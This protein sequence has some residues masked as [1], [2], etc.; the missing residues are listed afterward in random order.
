MLNDRDEKYDGQDDTEYHFSDEEVSYDVDGSD[1]PKAAAPVSAASAG[2][3]TS[4]LQSKRTLISVGAFITLVFVVYKMVSPASTT[5]DTDIKPITTVAQQA[6]MPAAATKSSQ[7][8]TAAMAQS[9]LPASQPVAAPV[10]T[11]PVATPPISEQ[12]T[13]QA[14]AKPAYP[15]PAAAVV[16]EAQPVAPQASVPAQVPDSGNP[17]ASVANTPPSMPATDQPY[18]VPGEAGMDMKVVT[19]A[20]QNERLTSQL[21]SQYDQRISEYQSQNKNLQEQLQSLSSHVADMEAKMSQMIQSMP[22]AGQEAPKEA[23]VEAAASPDQMED[24]APKLAYTVQAI[25]PGRAWLKSDNGDTITVAEGDTVKDVGRITKI[26]PYDGV[27]EINTG[28]KTVTLSYGTG[29]G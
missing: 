12:P 23:P 24:V 15:A 18:A 5:P 22:R 21:Q 6:T 3:T 16:P 19:L 11:M 4:I 14:E 20:A 13:V 1:A 29:G 17:Y 8:N 2:G 7:F 25:I 28:K 10:P 9:S 26:D 27:V